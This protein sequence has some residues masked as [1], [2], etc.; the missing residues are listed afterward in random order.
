MTNCDIL[1]LLG[2]LL[3]VV[4]GIPGPLHLLVVALLVVSFLNSLN[5]L[6][7]WWSLTVPVPRLDLHLVALH[8]TVSVMTSYPDFSHVGR[9]EDAPEHVHQGDVITIDKMPT[10]HRSEI[11]EAGPHL[12]FRSMC[13]PGSRT[14]NNKHNLVV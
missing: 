5:S 1:L 7:A 8:T 13:S 14:D 11:A 2:N 12:G 9:M 3:L 6:H 10:T 4:L